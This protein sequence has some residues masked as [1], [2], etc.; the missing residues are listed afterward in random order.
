[1]KHVICGQIPGVLTEKGKSQA[2]KIGKYMA[3]KSDD[4]QFHH[5]YVSDLQRTKDTFHNILSHASHI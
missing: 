5:I 4:Y 1:M 2:Q 3:K